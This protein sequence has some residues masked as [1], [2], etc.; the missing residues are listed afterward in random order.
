M[1]EKTFQ[2][3]KN[4]DN[5][6]LTDLYYKKKKKLGEALQVEGRWHLDQNLEYE[7]GRAPGMV[8]YRFS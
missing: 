8:K 6:L 4:W 7:P 3:N 5:L 1:K 2:T